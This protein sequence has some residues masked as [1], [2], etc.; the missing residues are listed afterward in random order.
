MKVVREENEYAIP[1][2]TK[3]MDITYPQSIPID[4]QAFL[5]LPKLLDLPL[6]LAVVRLSR[7]LGEVMARLDQAGVKR[8][9]LHS[10]AAMAT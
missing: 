2:L 1:F 6:Q 9:I 5:P 8:A 3:K 4:L 7:E 10:M